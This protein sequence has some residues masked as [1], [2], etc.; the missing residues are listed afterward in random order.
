VNIFEAIKLDTHRG[1]SGSPGQDSF[2]P[3]PVNSA[4]NALPGTR[5]KLDELAAR[6]LRGEEM[7]HQDDRLDW[8]D[9]TPSEIAKLLAQRKTNRRSFDE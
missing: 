4:T 6:V 2:E 9:A 5:D 7:W 3:I 1:R 8:S